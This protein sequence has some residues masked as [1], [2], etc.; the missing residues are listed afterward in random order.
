M[1]LDPCKHTQGV[2]SAYPPKSSTVHRVGI[3]RGANGFIVRLDT[4]RFF[5]PGVSKDDQS[6]VFS[7]AEDLGAFL[8]ERL[9]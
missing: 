6:Y 9:K 1:A 4:D 2:A 8:A 5:D 3:T 7:T